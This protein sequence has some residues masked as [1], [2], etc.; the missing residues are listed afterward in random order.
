[1][2]W[3][4]TDIN[5]IRVNKNK[6]I[7]PAC[8]P[9]WTYYK[10]QQRTQGKGTWHHRAYKVWEGGHSVAEEVTLEL[11]PGERRGVT[12]GW[13][14]AFQAEQWA[15]EKQLTARQRGSSHWMWNC[16]GCPCLYDRVS[17]KLIPKN[18]VKANKSFPAIHQI[19]AA[20]WV[21]RFCLR[22]WENSGQA[23]YKMGSPPVLKSTGWKFWIPLLLSLYK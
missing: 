11:R 1:M 18:I 16:H 19:P 15:Y 10:P 3:H 4:C 22:K 6:S 23:F 5:N 2:P 20:N 21:I 13:E 12:G 14:G 9:E 7:K 8:C 17:I